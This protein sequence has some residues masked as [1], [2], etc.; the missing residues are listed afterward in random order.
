MA[1]NNLQLNFHPQ[2]SALAKKGTLR[3]GVKL[4]VMIGGS[5]EREQDFVVDFQKQPNDG[6]CDDDM[7]ESMIETHL[8]YLMLYQTFDK[9]KQEAADDLN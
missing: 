1:N 9:I 5:H 2:L 7:V 8:R 4:R 6:L 3:I